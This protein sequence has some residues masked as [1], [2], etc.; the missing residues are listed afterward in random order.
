[1]LLKHLKMW[2]FRQ[3]YGETEIVFSTD[4]NKNITLVHG[5]NGV[6]KTTLLNA[7]LWCLFEY[8]TPD[9]EQP[10]DLINY[11][12]AKENVKSCKIEV[13]F[14]HEG[15]ESKKRGER[16]EQYWTKAPDTGLTNCFA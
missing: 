6:G 5:E 1:M 13:C 7:I 4:P 10:K 9:F 2:N 12:A 15:H 14:E 11:E 3:F 8:L 16:R